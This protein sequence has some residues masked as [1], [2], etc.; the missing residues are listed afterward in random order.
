[1]PV[2]EEIP[3]GEVVKGLKRVGKSDV[4]GRLF[5]RPNN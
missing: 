2:L 4:S 5:T 1:M 3:F